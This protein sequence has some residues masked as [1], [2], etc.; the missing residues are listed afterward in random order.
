MHILDHLNI[1]S[2]YLRDMKGV[3]DNNTIIVKDFNT[4]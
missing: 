1:L 4:Y 2:K 3:M